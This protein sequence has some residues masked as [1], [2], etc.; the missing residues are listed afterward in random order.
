V[1][2][3]ASLREYL[4]VGMPHLKTAGE[5]LQV[6]VESGRVVAAFGPGLS[7]EY[8]Y[9]L[10]LTLLDFVDKDQDRLFALIIAWLSRHQRELLL[11]AELAENA[12]TFEVDD[13]GGGTLDLELT[14]PLTERVRARPREGGGYDLDHPFEEPISEDLAPPSLLHELY[15]N[16]ELLMACEAHHPVEP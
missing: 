16:G 8:R 6:R 15:A 13:L 9:S 14:L 4:T 7:F 12:L 2:K 1:Y 3:P 10:K 5:R 11:N